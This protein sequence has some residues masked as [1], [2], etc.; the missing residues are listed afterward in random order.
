MQ[1]VLIA[2]VARRGAIGKDGGMPWQ[3]PADLAHFR[4]VTMGAPVVMGRKTWESLPPRFR[5]LPGRRNLVVTRNAAWQADGAEAAPSLD[6]ALARLHDAERVAV[7]GGGELYRAALPRADA[8]VLT[9]IDADFDAD[10]FFP[11]WP[12]ERFEEVARDSHRADAGWDY[13]FVTYR[14]RA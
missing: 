14:R 8:L 7:I 12:R 1:L 2:A 3:L 9:E 11:D 6:A 5:P 4:H 10:T 13:H